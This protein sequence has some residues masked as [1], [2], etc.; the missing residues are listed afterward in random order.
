MGPPLP[1]GEHPSFDRPP[2]TVKLWRYTDLPKFVDL[3]TSK[4]L[5]LTNAE[6]LAAD[7]PYEGLPGAVQFPHRLWRSIE[8]VPEPL[9]LQILEIYTRGADR[10]PEAAF[11]SWF[12]IEEQRCFMTQAGRRNFYVSCWHAG[13][14]ESVAMWK[15]YGAP[16][17][18]VAIVTNGGR[19]DTALASNDESLY[20]GAVR[21]MEPGTVEIGMSNALDTIMRKRASYT[22]E[23]EVRLV[24][25]RTGE[26]HDP[27]ANFAW[28]EET[29]RFDNIIDDPKPITAGISLV[30]DLDVMIER[31]IVSPF[32]PAWYAP[33][34]ER[35]RDQLGCS[36][37]V[38]ASR[39]LKV[40]LALP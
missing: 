19:L 9:R 28:N 40:P 18:G 1:I 2:V 24:H 32:A 21:Y 30:C 4:R 31:V 22:Y 38:T 37:P 26:S 27:L 17:A 7:D 34:I 35:L 20:L 36:F 3:L 5:W 16:G 25:W 11:K 33:M 29:M 12:M 15:I 8:E 6:V 10:T 13:D 39:L 23:Q 14:H